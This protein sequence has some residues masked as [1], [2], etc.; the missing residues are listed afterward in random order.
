MLA[1]GAG[2][3][4]GAALGRDLVHEGLDDVASGLGRAGLKVL[5]RL[6]QLDIEALDDAVVGDPAKG[7]GLV[8]EAF[9]ISDE[10][11]RNERGGRR[12]RTDGFLRD[13]NSFLYGS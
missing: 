11:Q 1:R 2:L 6:I 12:S 10:V 7:L 4:G 5:P 3:V 8:L 13:D 9:E